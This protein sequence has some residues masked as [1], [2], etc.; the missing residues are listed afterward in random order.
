M[1]SKT[2]CH[3]AVELW[4]ADQRARRE[5]RQ[6]QVVRVGHDAGVGLHR[7]G[8]AEGV[9]TQHGH[10][11]EVARQ[12]LGARVVAAWIEERVVGHGA[13]DGRPRL[14]LLVPIDE[15]LLLLGTSAELARLDPQLGGGHGEQV[16]HPRGVILES[17]AGKVLLLCPSVL[18]HAR[19]A[20]RR[21]LE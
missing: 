20:A 6:A 3:S 2:R 17:G 21:A 1:G 10:G 11:L 19:Q 8:Q 5:Q 7:A 15:R 13:Q 12:R 18:E 14:R 16:H 9:L 4:V